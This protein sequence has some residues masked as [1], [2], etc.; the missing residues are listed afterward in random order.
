MP[1]IHALDTDELALT[2]GISNLRKFKSPAVGALLILAI[3]LG[4]GLACQHAPARMVFFDAMLMIPIALLAYHE[5]LVTGLVAGIVAAGADLVITSKV[6]GLPIPLYLASTS[7]RS[8]AVAKLFSMELV[9]VVISL[10]SCRARREALEAEHRTDKYLKKIYLLQRHAEQVERQ[11]RHQQEELE[12]DLLKYSSLVRLLEES[13]QKLYSNLEVDRLFQSLFRVL[14]ECFGSTSASVYLKN[15]A[16][17][18]YLL[19]HASETNTAADG[20]IPMM[21]SRDSLLVQKLEATQ[22]AVCWLE[23]P[24]AAELAASGHAAPAVIS[25]TLLDKGE[26]VGIINVHATNR[27]TQPD[28][29]LMAIVANTA[30][31]ALANARLFGEVQWFAE[32]DPLTKL[33]NRRTFHD[34]LEAQIDI[35]GRRSEPF[36]LLMLDIDHFKAFNDTYGHQAGDA[37]LEWF[38]G[39]CKK[40]AGEANLVCR[41]GGEEFTVIMPKATAEDGQVMA[42]K[43]RTHVERAG[44]RYGETV[45]KVTLSCGVAAFPD[46]GADGDELVRKADRAMYRAK[47]GGRNLVV[48]AKTG[49]GP[50]SAIVSYAVKTGLQDSGPASTGRALGRPGAL[51]RSPPASERGES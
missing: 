21:L 8:A 32:R 29:R 12:Q 35:A 3:L 17:G 10:L 5:G 37:V 20:Q 45:L 43:I 15:P 7:V 39:H 49:R 11:A 9:S 28:P 47:A 22:Q 42:E 24:Q 26:H 50:D 31:I 23:E 4:K 51:F 18:S 16:D 46:H 6:V 34:Q 41:Y 48:A 30:S 38:A 36:A 19:A 27:G 13:A 14:E 40:C 44:F 1:I 33:Y 25:A 2:G